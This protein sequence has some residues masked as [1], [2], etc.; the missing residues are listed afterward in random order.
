LKIRQET[1]NLLRMK[2]RLLLFLLVASVQAGFGQRVNNPPAMTGPSVFKPAQSMMNL[3]DMNRLEMHHS[4]SFGVSSFGGGQNL[5]EGLYTNTILY[6]FQAPVIM[7]MDVGVAH[8]P[9]G[10]QTFGPQ[11]KSAQVYLQN[12]MLQYRPADNMLFTF[13]FSQVPGG[14]SLFRN[15]Y[16]SRFGGYSE[17]DVWSRYY[18][19]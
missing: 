4:Y 17:Y 2:L 13:A 11:Q 18:G 15:P 3:I 19:Y 10:T 8:D 5:T 9:F 16:A 12:L 7:R 14:Y 1:V 6:H